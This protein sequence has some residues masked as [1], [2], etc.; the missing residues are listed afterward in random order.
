MEKPMPA[1]ARILLTS[2]LFAGSISYAAAH[3]PTDHSAAAKQTAA[4]AKAVETAA[5]LRDLWI[6]HVFWVRNVAFATLTKNEAAAKASEQQVVENAKAIAGAIEPFYGAA[7]KDGLF[8]LL[9]G[10][11]GAVKEYLVA[12]S[13]ADSSGQGKAIESLTKNAEDIAT[14]LSKANPHL[15]QDAVTGLLQAHGGH[16][17]QEIDELKAGKYEV[18]AITW[19]SMKSHMYVVSDALA[20]AIVKQFPNKF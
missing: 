11:Y 3:G 9:A 2:A 15:P 1:F 10:H 14:F 20:Q 19:E 4:S 16:H 13:A 5:A 7:A 18:E 12:A 17:V 8:K 6:G